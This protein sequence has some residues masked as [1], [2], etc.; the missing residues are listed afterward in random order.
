MF[1]TDDQDL[2]RLAT[3]V[4]GVAS[5][6]IATSKLT[7]LCFKRFL[8]ELEKSR[9]DPT[10]PFLFDEAQ[11]SRAL[12]FFRLLSHVKGDIA[13]QQLVLHEWA[14]FFAVNIFGW[15]IRATGARRFRQAYTFIPRGNSKSTTLSAVSLYE[16]F[17]TGKQADVFSLAT[18]N[19][20]ARIVWGDASAMMRAALPL[21]KKL[22]VDCLAHSIIQTRTN[23]SYRPLA[24]DATSLDGLNVSLAVV[25]ELHV[26]SREVFEVISTA[27][28][29]R[30]SSLLISI[31]TAGFDT[32]SVGREKYLWCKRILENEVTD[33]LTFALIYECPEGLSPYSEEAQRAANPMYGSSVRPEV[34]KQAAMQ[35]QQMPSARAAYLVKHLNIWMDSRSPWIDM[36]KWDACA[37]DTL[38]RE[39]FQGQPCWVGLDLATRSDIT[40]KVLVFPQPREDGN[41]E[42][43]VFC[44]SYLPEAAIEDGRNSAYRGWELEGWVKA[45][46]GNITDFAF[47]REDLV[48]DSRL[49]QIR[50]ACYD[51]WQATQLATE[52]QAQ[53]VMA[54]EVRQTAKMLSEP[55]KAIEAAV[56]QGRIKHDGN[57]ALRWMVSN[58]VCRADAAGN[59]FPR[60]ENDAQKIDGAVA[61]ITAMARAVVADG[62]NPYSETRGLQFIDLDED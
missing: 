24:S 56:L 45:T 12:R 37:D 57:K 29:K 28:G 50:E 40:A 11:A 17:G 43:I 62:V 2:A 31:S 19:Q 35:A 16:A 30:E 15:R 3:Y 9:N 38:K 22:G 7:V 42:Y 14:L 27:L 36:S 32:S 13:G 8:A 48:K 20:Q 55:M 33:D 26:V 60:K 52:L 54:V 41:T 25:D 39:D 18:T 58:V 51:P 21:K 47:I 23:S 4:Q 6:S 53:G 61:L 5:G 49:F 1:D 44:D 59:V 34:L 10:Y 46:P